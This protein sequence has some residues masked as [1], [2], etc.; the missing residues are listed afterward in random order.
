VVLWSRDAQV[1]AA[2]ERDRRCPR[3]PDAPLPPPLEA[4]ADPRRLAR[5]ARLLV[6]AVASTDI[7][8]R[9]REI[10]EVIDGS[11]LVVHAIG[12]L[13]SPGDERCSEVIAQATP[14]LRLGALAGP[15]LP[16]DLASGQFASMV[17][18]SRFD[19]VV[20]EARRLLNAP[21][22]LRVYGSSDLVGVEL[23]AA[24]AGAYTVAFGIADTIGIGIGPRA[25]LVTRA[26]AEASR[27]VTAA[28][29]DPRSV[30]GLAGL[31]NLMV[32]TGPGSTARDYA[33]GG[34]LAGGAGPL[35]EADLT[36]G[37]RAALAGTRLAEL[38]ELNHRLVEAIPGGIVHVNADGSIVTANEEAL[39]VLG[40][41]V[42]TITGRYVQQWDPVTVWEDGSPCRVEDY[43]VTRALVTGQPQPRVTIGVR[44]PDGHV[45]WAVFTAV[46]I[47][48][49][50][51]GAVTGAIVTFLDITERKRLENRVRMT[52]RL[53]TI[54]M[55]AAGVAHEINNPLT[56]VMGN[57]EL[58]VRGLARL[59]P[60][61]ATCAAEAAD[62]ARRIRDVVS[63]LSA[64]SQAGEGPRTPTRV[65]D[66]LESCFRIVRHELEHRATL[67]RD[68]DE[69]L[70]TIVSDPSRLGQVFLNLLVN[71]VQAIPAGDARH[72]RIEV[73]TRRAGDD[74]VEVVVTDTGPG[75]APEVLARIFE[76][77]VTT[78][79]TG[80]GTGLGLYISHSI[81]TA[82]GGELSVRSEPGQGAQ[83]TVRLPRGAPAALPAAPPPRAVAPGRARILV[84]DDESAI[85]R[86]LADLLP[87]HDVVTAS[88]GRAA[89]EALRG[90]DFDVV[91]CDLLMPDLTGMELH[92][93][94]RA[95]WPALADRFVFMTGATS[96]PQVRQFLQS[97]PGAVLAKPFRAADVERAV[98]EVLARAS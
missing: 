13:A 87:G 6:L 42:D 51:T 78:K 1:V 45:S 40:M 15:A 23:A 64:L 76:P 74:H 9:A 69:A 94:V 49:P 81:V 54:G 31:G 16:A 95:W 37:A 52:D 88:S 98:D 21:P 79:S 72:Q 48:D 75:I 27:L 18:A 84:V 80:G 50:G 43:P 11:H 66:V 67:V 83:V 12:A 61:L 44:R 89:I 38:L 86:C 77:F 60:H 3:L 34:R 39:R 32:R 28:G 92:A 4:T 25:V 10:G 63:D 93:H 59:D 70:P 68:F 90:H 71:A 65:H 55:L 19:E 30:G 14:A 57:L 29:G 85:R 26:L 8:Q 46:P 33:L 24:L 47:K 62:G 96:S 97:P 91:V 58:L 36:E 22:V 56:Y 5:E 7:R 17:V 53:A 35:G 2:I 73:R 41:G 20:G 82:L